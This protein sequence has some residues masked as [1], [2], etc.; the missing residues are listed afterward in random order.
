MKNEILNDKVDGDL[1]FFD[2]S[3]LD[4]SFDVYIEITCLFL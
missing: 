2:E 4:D 1:M 3:H